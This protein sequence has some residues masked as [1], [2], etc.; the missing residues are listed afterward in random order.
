[1]SLRAA[2]LF[3]VASAC[4]ALGTGLAACGGQSH[5]KT[6]TVKLT[7]LANNQENGS[8]PGSP[9][10]GG[11]VTGDQGAQPAPKPPSAGAQQQPSGTGGNAEGKAIFAQSCASCHTLAAA[12]A[13]GSVGP[14][15]DQLKPGKAAIATQVTKGGGA[16][17]AFGGTLAPKQIDAVA[18][19][20]AAVAGS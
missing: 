10:T 16:M 20:V 14:N 5:D 11:L 13:S 2:Q 15:L 12:G 17:P 19:Y 4:V 3:A 8:S 18:A 6:A 1:M 7:E 9:A